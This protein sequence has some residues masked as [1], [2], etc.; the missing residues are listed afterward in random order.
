MFWLLQSMH[1]NSK[2]APTEGETVSSSQNSMN[3]LEQT[4]LEMERGTEDDK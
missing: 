1:E 4:K 2:R 3:A